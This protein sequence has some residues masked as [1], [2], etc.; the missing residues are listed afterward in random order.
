MMRKIAVFA[1]LSVNL[2]QTARAHVADES[3]LRVKVEPHRLETRLTF[4]LFTLTRF[5]KIDSDGDT[6][7]SMAELTA[8]EPGIVDYLNKHVQLR[9]NQQKTALGT[10]ARLAWLWPNAMKSPPMTELEYT[11]RNVDVTFVHEVKDRLIESLWLE[12]EIFEQTGPLQTIRGVFEQDDLV[13]EMPF[14]A[15]EPEFLYATGFADDPF[16]KE[17]ESKPA[18]ASTGQRWWMVRAMVLMALLVLGR[19]T[20]LAARAR[21]AVTRRRRARR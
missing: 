20:V 9:I 18:T 11:A 5:V 17:A 16:V 13:T 15:Q 1:L 14:S 7:I 19:R 12:F 6:K 2:C 21:K 3:N 10:E 8:A 4:N